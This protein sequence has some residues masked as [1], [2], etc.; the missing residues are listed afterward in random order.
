MESVD[1]FV[2]RPGGMIHRGVLVTSAS[3]DASEEVAAA[4]GVLSGLAAPFLCGR[5]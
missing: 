4:G 2:K 1:S 5:W 3:R